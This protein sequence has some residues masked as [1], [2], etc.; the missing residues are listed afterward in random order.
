MVNSNYIK[1]SKANGINQYISVNTFSGTRRKV[2]DKFELMNFYIDIDLKEIG[3]D[4]ELYYQSNY[5]YEFVDKI[6]G[7]CIDLK[8]PKPTKINFSGNGLHVYWKIKLTNL[9][10]LCMVLMPKFVLKFITKFKKN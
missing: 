6:I 2:D 3:A 1:W 7:K 9:E 4:K 10:N 5:Q 8:I